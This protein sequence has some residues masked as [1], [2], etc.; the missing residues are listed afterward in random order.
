VLLQREI[1]TW[2]EGQ[3]KTMSQKSGPSWGILV[4]G[5]R[6]LAAAVFTRYAS[7][8]A[9]PISSFGIKSLS[10]A[11]GPTCSDAL[12]RMAATVRRRYAKRFL[13]VLFKNPTMSRVIYE[14]AI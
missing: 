4:H 7:L 9:Q 5:N 11:L 2:I 10:P 8:L 13:A 6:L 1:D 3:K 14:S 12:S